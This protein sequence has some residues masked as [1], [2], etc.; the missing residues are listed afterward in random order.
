LVE[1]VKNR[2]ASWD[3]GIGAAIEANKED[4]SLA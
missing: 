3:I 4:F 2:C 1:L